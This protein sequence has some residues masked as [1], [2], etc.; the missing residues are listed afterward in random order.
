MS[1]EDHAV[2]GAALSVH[3]PN[4]FFYYFRPMVALP[5]WC[6]HHGQAFLFGACDSSCPPAFV[7]ATI[8]PGSLGRDLLIPLPLYPASLFPVA[9]RQHACLE[10]VPVL[11]SCPKFSCFGEHLDKGLSFAKILP[12]RFDGSGM[13]GVM[14]T[15]GAVDLMVV[16]VLEFG[17]QRACLWE[18]LCLPF[19]SKPGLTSWISCTNFRCLALVSDE[20]TVNSGLDLGISADCRRKVPYDLLELSLIIGRT[21]VDLV[22][23]SANRSLSFFVDSTSVP[24]LAFCSWHLHMIDPIFIVLGQLVYCFSTTKCR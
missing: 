19:L 18:S 1:T 24:F 15:A 11:E 22:F 16:F 9:L 8:F 20:L 5:F 13:D 2:I 4:S 21:D 7:W 12:V 6:L 3:H 10:R 17:S 23:V 14:L